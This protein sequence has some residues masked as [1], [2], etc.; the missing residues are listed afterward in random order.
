MSY[1]VCGGG[2]GSSQEQSL[3]VDQEANG[4]QM[5]SKKSH[6]ADTRMLGD[7]KSLNGDQ[8]KV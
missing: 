8:D 5:R 4:N 2:N 1:G 3:G 7:G 6:V